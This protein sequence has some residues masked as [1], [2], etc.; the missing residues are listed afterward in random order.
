MSTAIFYASSTGNT[1]TVAEAISKELGGVEVFDIT[2][3]GF[4]QVKN[5]D[6]VI[7]GVSTWGEGDLQDDWEDNI[8]EFSKIDFSDKTVALFCL[9][10]QDSYG[11]TFLDSMGI[12]YEKIIA[13]GGNVIGNFDI[14]EDYY[15]DESGAIRDDT[16]V[17]LGLDVDNQGELTST[18]IQKWC[19]D[20]RSNIL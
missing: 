10:D 18:R 16:F 2:G 15:H 1:E 7:F 14:D 5:Y 6:K 9:G 20:I 3:C 12:V 8:E 17:G 11:E 4:S 13:N 19:N